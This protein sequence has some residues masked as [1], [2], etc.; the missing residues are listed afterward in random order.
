MNVTRIVYMGMSPLEI[1]EDIADPGQFEEGQAEEG[2]EPQRWRYGTHRVWSY[3]KASL[4]RRIGQVNDG[5]QAKFR[6]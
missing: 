3:V 6:Y 1:E 4:P 5:S 2:E